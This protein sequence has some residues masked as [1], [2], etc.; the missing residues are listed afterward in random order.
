M[1]ER[2]FFIGQK[3]KQNLL[4]WQEYK[5]AISKKT[6]NWIHERSEISGFNCSYCLYFMLYHWI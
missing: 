3:T 2:A 5:Q 1:L 4:E 6:K